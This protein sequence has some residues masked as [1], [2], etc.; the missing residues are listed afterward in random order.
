M[1]SPI[2]IKPLATYTMKQVCQWARCGPKAV[3]K[4]VHA[5]HLPVIREGKG[6]RFL[7]EHLLSWAQPVRRA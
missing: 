5:G 6:W 3:S 1:P 7:G 4:A 2:E